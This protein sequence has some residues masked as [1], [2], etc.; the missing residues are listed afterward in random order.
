MKVMLEDMLAVHL[1]RSIA[2]LTCTS[3]KSIAG[4]NSQQSI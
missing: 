4:M 1:T 3:A 2:E